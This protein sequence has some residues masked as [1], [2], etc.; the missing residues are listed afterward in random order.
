VTA[1]VTAKR[2]PFPQPNPVGVSWEVL[3]FTLGV[4]VL[5]GIL[6]GLAPALQTSRVNLI[7]EL[8]ASG[9]MVQTASAGGRAVR[10]V[11][12]TV[13]IALSLALLAGAAL[14]L[15]TF[16]N[17]RNVQIG[18][19]AE[20]VLTAGVLPPD[21][22]YS[23]PAKEREF[24]DRLLAALQASPGVQAAAITSELPIQ[25]STNGYVKVDGQPESASKGVLVQWAAVTPDYFR[26]MG[27]PLLEGRNL[28]DKDMDDF[29]VRAQQNF[30]AYK[31]GD[32]NRKLN[33]VVLDVLIN[34][35]MAK[36]FWA[37]QDPIGRQFHQNENTHY[38]VAGVVGDVREWGLRTA[39]PPEAYFPLTR[40]L[41]GDG[42][43]MNIAV[44]GQGKPENLANVIR[45][46]VRNVDSTL[47]V[48][49]VQTIRD[50]AS[51][52]MANDTNQ[53]F[54][55]GVFAGLAL[56]LAAVGTYGVMSYLVTQRTGEIGI[57]VALGASRGDVLWLVAR[58]GL[59]LAAIGT[60]IGVAGA[61]ASSKVMQGMLF[62]VQPNDP[63]TLV[64]VS[65]VMIGVAAVATLVPAMRAM[66]VEPIT[67]LRYE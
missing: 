32:T 51:D 45:G 9:K 22:K 3:V 46:A 5:I 16:S 54:L 56:L 21:T 34:Q 36:K 66:R 14:L 59:T 27:V 30:D 17:L 55:L 29:A 48:Y 20:H 47:A 64:I 63:A 43:S 37:A 61:V 40:D 60:A 28:N 62:G 8:K 65:A 15:R 7:D 24:Y 1:L 38:R 4:S 39:T 44:L 52:S 67:A 42:Q 33:P 19:S 25:G 18:I 10:N 49:Q 23:T 50:I 57:R 31:A 11:L 6:F 41:Y 35:T 53:T 13:E 58:Q 2:L 12:V 26:V